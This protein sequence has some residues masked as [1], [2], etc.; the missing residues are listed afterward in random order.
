[1][2]VE[3]R[4]FATHL[5]PPPNGNRNHREDTPWRISVLASDNG[6]NWMPNLQ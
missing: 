6:H 4:Y 2:L 5:T 3:Y 1:M